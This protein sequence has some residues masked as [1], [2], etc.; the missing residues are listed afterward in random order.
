MRAHK[1]EIYTPGTA[2]MGSKAME[3]TTRLCGPGD[4]SALSL[5]AQGTILETYAGLADGDDL[6]SYAIAESSVADF[7]RI[8]A[9]E[10]IRAWI[11][12]TTIGKCAV[13]YAV[14]VSDE[15]GRPF[16]SFELKRLYVFHRF[17]GNGLGR[18][19]MEDVLSF[20]KG[21]KSETIWLQVHE[22]NSRAIQFYKRFG[23]VPTGADLFPVGKSSFRVLNLELALAR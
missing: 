7:R 17:H 19:L 15:H 22:A 18:T 23:F 3:F 14:A 2:T 16:S 12:E 4:E 11:A 8:V 21:M 6:V 20:A 9:S 1:R 5:V 10:H 13:G